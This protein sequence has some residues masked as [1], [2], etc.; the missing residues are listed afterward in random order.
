M[1]GFERLVVFNLR[2]ILYFRFFGCCCFL[3]VDLLVKLLRACEGAVRSLYLRRLL[4]ATMQHS[5]S[6]RKSIRNITQLCAW[7]ST[8]NS[9]STKN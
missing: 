2:F 6:I 9:S 5:S 8:T 1:S 4:S 7:K 3:F